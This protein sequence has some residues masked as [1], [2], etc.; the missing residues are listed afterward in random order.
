MKLPSLVL[1][2]GLIGNL[3]Y[4]DPAGRIR[5]ANVRTFDLLGYGVARDADVNRLTLR[6]QADHVAFHIE[7][8][9][10]DR[11]WILGHS[12]GGAVAMILA[13]LRPELIAGIINVEGNFTLVDA[14]WSRTIAGRTP[15]DWSER[16]QAM[17]S[18]IPGTVRQWGLEFSSPHAEWVRDILAN[19]PPRTLRAMSRAILK[20]TGTIAYER[21]LRRVIKRD[22]PL[23]L[24]AG[25]RSAKDWDVPG[26]I[27]SAARSYAEIPDTG[28]LMMF[29]DPDA[30]CRAVDTAIAQSQSDS[31]ALRD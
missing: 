30:F 13:D 5:N 24:I 19:Q 1:I 15:E 25:E 21:L 26:F 27:R 22:L 29:E 17:Q 2:H 3:A 18:D 31:G 20:E 28:H 12:M 14:F 23:H 7:A 4:F 16:Y 10:A 8:F 6:E 11:V 9:A